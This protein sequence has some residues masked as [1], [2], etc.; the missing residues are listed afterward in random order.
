MSLIPFSIFDEIEAGAANALLVKWGHKMGALERPFPSRFFALSFQGHPVCIVAH[1]CL[2]ATHVGGGLSRLTRENTIELSRLC[3][4]RP[5]IC[6]IGLRLW[7]EAVLPGLNVS[8]AISYQDADLHNG[9]T[10]RFDGWQRAGKSRSGPDTR[11]GRAGR[12]KWIWV[13][14]P[15]EER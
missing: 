6:R 1:S 3:S 11:S 14:P 2:I 13:Y 7:R 4:S 10:Y 5:G 15:L 9:N 8:H 12:N